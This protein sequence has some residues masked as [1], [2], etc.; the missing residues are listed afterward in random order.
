MT[1]TMEA[2]YNGTE[3]DSV[4]PA[5]APAAAFGVPPS[6]TFK[7]RLQNF[8]TQKAASRIISVALSEALGEAVIA[9]I[10]DP[11]YGING[12]SSAEIIT[13]LMLHY[14]APKP[15]EVEALRNIIISYGR[16]DKV[17]IN[18]TRHDKAYQTLKEAGREVSAADKLTNLKAAIKTKSNL[19]AAK[20]SYERAT[21]EADQT[22]D[23]LYK[24]A[25][26]SETQ[27]LTDESSFSSS[28]RSHVANAAVTDSAYAAADM[29][30][31]ARMER[32]EKVV[33]K[34]FEKFLSQG[35]KPTPSKVS[36][37]SEPKMHP[38]TALDPSHDKYCGKCGHNSSHTTRECSNITSDR[39]KK[40][41]SK[42]TTPQ[43]RNKEAKE[44]FDSQKK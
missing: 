39:Q 30:M 32:L 7:T 42:R 38:L 34:G 41:F 17:A 33:E 44:Y 20:T 22:Y 31:S 10:G 43:Q 24:A 9:K 5:E 25:E 19:N 36:G 18:K 2:L 11:S 12:M 28:S 14:G 4:Q 37:N 21:E 6:L 8:H 3:F 35:G 40:I 15:D 26:K 13:A 27:G 16:E 29:S 23:G 1:A